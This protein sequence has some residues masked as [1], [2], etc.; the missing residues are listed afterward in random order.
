MCIYVCLSKIVLSWDFT[1][2]NCLGLKTGLSHVIISVYILDDEGFW[3][4]F[5]ALEFNVIEEDDR[6]KYP[7][8]HTGDT[9]KNCGL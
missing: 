1:P 4:H 3:G 9:R 6:I 7:K 8:H 5:G 2:S